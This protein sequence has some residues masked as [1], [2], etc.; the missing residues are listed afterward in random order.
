MLIDVNVDPKNFAKR[1]RE[2]AAKKMISGPRQ[3]LEIMASSEKS[4]VK[5]GAVKSHWYGRVLPGSQTLAEY[6]AVLGESTDWLLT[7]QRIKL[8]KEELAK[9]FDD[10]IVNEGFEKRD[11]HPD[12]QWLIN[13]L[14][15]ATDS[16]RLEVVA[17]AKI[18]L[19]KTQRE[20]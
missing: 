4:S 11:V 19:N 18:I 3:L 1:L 20:S 2:A 7:G 15:T 10:Y 5:E 16:K 17:I 6:A 14:D 12:I 8:T 13:S 9:I